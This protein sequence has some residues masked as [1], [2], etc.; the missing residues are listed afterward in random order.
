MKARDKGAAKDELHKVLEGLQLQSLQ[1]NGGV[2]IA[3]FN[4]GITPSA[5]LTALSTAS[6]EVNYFRNISNSSRRFFANL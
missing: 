3:T 4:A 2:Y 6:F 1:Y 5:V